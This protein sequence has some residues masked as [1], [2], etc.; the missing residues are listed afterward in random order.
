LWASRGIAA[1]RKKVAKNREKDRSGQTQFPEE[2]VARL[3]RA[4]V[5]HIRTWPEREPFMTMAIRNVQ[6]SAAT[7]SALN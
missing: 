7:T 2:L 3:L 6:F 1:V 5:D 4:I